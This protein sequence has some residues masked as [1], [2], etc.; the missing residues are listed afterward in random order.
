MNTDYVK[1]KS[2]F[3]V[4]LLA[5][6]LA[7][8]PFKDEL[9]EI[10]ILLG[11][12]ETSLLKITIIFFILL[13][14]ATYMYAL[15][16]IRYGYGVKIQS[17]LK[18]ILSIANFLYIV[19]LLFPIAI[20]LIW[21]ISLIINTIEIPKVLVENISIFIAYLIA[22]ALGIISGIVSKKMTK[23]VR[24]QFAKLLKEQGEE[25]LQKASQLYKNGFYSESILEI[26]KVLELNLR[27]KLEGIGIYTKNINIYDL[28]AL[29][30]KK[31]II[32]KSDV[33]NID[34]LR[35]W[36]NRAAHF[37]VS[38]TK[39]DA[40]LALEITKII[41]DKI[42][43]NMQLYKNLSG[44]SNVSSYM[45]GDNYIEVR[46]R[47][48]SAYLYNDSVTGHDN[49]EIM[50]DLAIKGEGLNSFINK[51]VRKNYASKLI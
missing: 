25:Q 10:F 27:G 1:N 23:N 20:F 29:S 8:S 41:L 35:K 6:F 14:L 44:G 17:Y 4:A 47:D 13:T 33:E 43:K 46:F 37:D 2:T 3:A 21:I 51:H 32:M 16:H 24:H 30:L 34:K 40:N 26:F 5:A 38:F 42:N 12:W 36:R 49:V 9:D 31:A 22:L 15:N 28:I 39:K 50:K 11:L 18:W 48:G 7:F 45:M 19:A